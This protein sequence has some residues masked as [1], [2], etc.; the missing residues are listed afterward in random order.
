LKQQKEKTKEESIR[1]L[2]RFIKDKEVKLLAKDS[3][4]GINPLVEI[5]N[6]LT[7]QEIDIR[8]KRLNEIPLMRQRGKWKRGGKKEGARKR[9]GVY[10][11]AP[12]MDRNGMPLP[13][14]KQKKP[15][16]KRLRQK[17]EFEEVVY[18]SRLE[19]EAMTSKDRNDAVSR[20][21]LVFEQKLKMAHLKKQ[22]AQNAH[23]KLL[24]KQKTKLAKQQ[25][26]WIKPIEKKNIAA[27]TA[28]GLGKKL[29]GNQL[30]KA[31]TKTNSNN[32]NPIQNAFL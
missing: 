3:N 30:T 8:L 18:K 11:M 16:K 23:Q 28:K 22:S 29:L 32:P 20:G 9:R 4:S 24:N 27:L 6:L 31:A 26:N 5:L 1:K 17:K 14:E 25:T 19:L 10:L 12:K 2:D 13:L 21:Q 15:Y 7:L